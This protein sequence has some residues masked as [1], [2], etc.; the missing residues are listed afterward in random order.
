MHD[1]RNDMADGACIRR[2][3]SATERGSTQVQR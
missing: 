1:S 2:V 3:P